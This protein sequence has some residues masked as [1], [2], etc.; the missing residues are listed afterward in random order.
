MAWGFGYN[1]REVDELNIRDL[2]VML[3]A[4]I[5]NRLDAWQRSAVIATK[6]HNM[7][8]PR[9]EDFR[10]QEPGDLYPSL[11]EGGR[12]TDEEWLREV[13]DQFARYNPE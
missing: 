5:E 10:P 1:P 12:K 6:V 3:R 2:A 11:F 7:G 13:K 4:A 9:G 8:G